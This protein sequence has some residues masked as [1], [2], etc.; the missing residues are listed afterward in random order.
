M[1]YPTTSS[2]AI[3]RLG[4]IGPVVPE[5]GPVVPVLLARFPFT[6]RFAA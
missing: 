3:L 5:L 4:L 2:L 1:L 6:A